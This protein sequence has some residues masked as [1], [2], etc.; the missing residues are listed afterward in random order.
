MVKLVVT[1]IIVAIKRQSTF[2]KKHIGWQLERLH[3][4]KDIMKIFNKA[5]L[6]QLVR[7]LFSYSECDVHACSNI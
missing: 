1:L 7:F 5:L 6:G 3:C 2:L 4:R